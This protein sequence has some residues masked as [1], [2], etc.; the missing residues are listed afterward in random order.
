MRELFSNDRQKRVQQG[1]KWTAA[2][3]KSSLAI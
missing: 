2:R 3:I 1:V